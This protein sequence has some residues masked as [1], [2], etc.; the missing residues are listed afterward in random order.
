MPC[1]GKMYSCVVVVIH[2]DGLR[3]TLNCGHQ[4]AYCSSLRLYMSTEGHSGMILTE[5]TRRTRRK[6][7]PSATLSTTN[8]TWIDPGANV[9]LRGER[10]ATNRLSHGTTKYRVND[11]E[12]RR[13]ALVV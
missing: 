10:P 2:A 13:V 7:C 4:R 6:T 1:L 3:L 8:P 9:G 5:E 12:S 11:C